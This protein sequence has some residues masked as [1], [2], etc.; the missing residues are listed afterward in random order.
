MGERTGGRTRRVV[1]HEEKGGRRKGERKR[2]SGRR[3]KRE[4]ERERERGRERVPRGES[5]SGNERGS[6]LCFAER[7]INRG[8]LA[9]TDT[10]GTF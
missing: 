9:P 1:E 6:G 2:A 7:G 10:I 8:S 4:E 5:E 3:E